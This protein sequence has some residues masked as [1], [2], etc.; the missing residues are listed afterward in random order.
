[1]PARVEITLMAVLISAMA[2]LAIAGSSRISGPV[3][4]VITTGHGVH[5]SDLFV[6]A[7][8]SVCMAWCWRLWRRTGS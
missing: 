1:M 6:C 2:L 4:Q 5:V 7:A 8:W 3:V